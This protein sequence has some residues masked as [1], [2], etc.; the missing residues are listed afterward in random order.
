MLQKINFVTNEQKLKEMAYGDAIYAWLLLHSHY[1]QDENHNYIYKRDFS[2]VDIAKDIGRSRQTVS[3][4]FNELL[5]LSED[6]NNRRNLIWYDEGNKRYVL[7]CFRDFQRL[8]SETILNLFRVCSKAPRREELIKTYAWL[9]KKYK[10]KEKEI[11]YT[12]MIDTFGHSRGN[13]ETYNRYKDILTTL[14]GAGLV[15]FRTD[16]TNYRNND[17]TYG[18][19]LYVYQVN[20]KADKDWLDK[21]T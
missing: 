1:D 16:T 19:T 12:E 21:N 2:Y 4:R 13:E 5:K 17:G 6:E 11:S 9:M 15:K 7:P 20:D 10:N 8:D 3:K 18:K 14:Q